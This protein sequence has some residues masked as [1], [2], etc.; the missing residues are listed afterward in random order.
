MCFLSPHPRNRLIA[1]QFAL[2]GA[3][4]FWGGKGSLESLL[5]KVVCENETKFPMLGRK[6]RLGEVQVG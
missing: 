4:F 1:W 5:I 2:F 6:Y 3:F